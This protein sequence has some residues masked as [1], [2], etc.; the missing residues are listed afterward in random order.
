M[1]RSAGV[2]GFDSLGEAVDGCNDAAIDSGFS[3]GLPPIR[4]TSFG[5]RNGKTRPIRFG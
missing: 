4:N 5:K 2:P 3:A 1:F